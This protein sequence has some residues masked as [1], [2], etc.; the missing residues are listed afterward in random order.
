MVQ[1]CHTAGGASDTFH[2][3]STHAA[4]ITSQMPQSNLGVMAYHIL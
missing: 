3:L 4:L 2:L 1:P